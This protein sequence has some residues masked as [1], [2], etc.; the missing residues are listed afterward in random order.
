MNRLR[1][2]GAFVVTALIILVGLS[3]IF[4]FEKFHNS[5]PSSPFGFIWLLGGMLVFHPAFDYWLTISKRF[6]KVQ[7]EDKSK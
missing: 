5:N 4:G 3:C 1:K 7:D 6:F 2:I